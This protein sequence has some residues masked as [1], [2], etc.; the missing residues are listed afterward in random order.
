[1]A[2]VAVASVASALLVVTGGAQDFLS[3]FQPSQ[4]ARRPGHGRGR[5]LPRGADELWVGQRRVVDRLPTRA[6][7]CRRGCRGR[8]RRTVVTDLPAGAPAAPRYAVVSG[9]VIAFTFNAALARAAAARAGGQLPPHARGAGRQ[10]AVRV[11]RARGGRLLRCRSRRAAPGWQRAHRRG[12]RRRH[13]ANADRLLDRVSPRGSSRTIC[14][15][16]PAS[17]PGSHRRSTRSVIPPRPSPCPSPSTSRAA[18]RSPS[19]ARADC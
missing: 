10:H 3:L 5:P 1:M 7:R 13:V 4:L 11:D 15:P 18:R 8:P 16:Y 2:G 6:G 9:G 14:S 17:P 19:T 12:V